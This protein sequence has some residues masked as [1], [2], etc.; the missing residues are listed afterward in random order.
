MALKLG[1]IAAA[2]DNM[3]LLI[4]SK[5]CNI[6]NVRQNPTL[7]ET[8]K[9]LWQFGIVCIIWTLITITLSTGLAGYL[10]WCFLRLPR[11]NKVC[12]Q[13]NDDGDN[14]KL[15]HWWFCG[16]YCG[17]KPEPRSVTRSARTAVWVQEH[18]K[19]ATSTDDKD[20]GLRPTNHNHLGTG[21]TKSRYSH[22]SPFAHLDS[23]PFTASC[24]HDHKNRQNRL[25]HHPHGNKEHLGHDFTVS[26]NEKLFHDPL[27]F[28][29]P[30]EKRC[31]APRVRKTCKGVQERLQELQT[32]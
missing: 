10:I 12:Y 16:C 5:F 2:A 31:A 4:V 9:I 6:S 19:C 17:L 32:V 30:A 7:T 18:G 22:V 26:M 13:M 23:D 1:N 8:D 3:I 28:N 21:R 29:F 11:Q 24:G 14:A 15:G 20:R 27:G 25:N